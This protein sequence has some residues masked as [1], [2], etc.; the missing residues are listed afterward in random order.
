MTPDRF[1]HYAL[2]NEKHDRQHYELFDGMTELVRLMANKESTQQQMEML[3]GLLSEHFISE[4]KYMESIGYPFIEPHSQDHGRMVNRLTQMVK[5]KA[6]GLVVKN[7]AYELEEL[8]IQHIE[9]HDRQVA[10]FAINKNVAV[11]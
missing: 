7:M 5:V 1:V 4:V 11:E 8:F 3:L 10:D 9:Y 2:G 6:D